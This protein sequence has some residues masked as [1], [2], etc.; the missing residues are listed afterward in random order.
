MVFFN[1][2]EIK[3]LSLKR[4]VKDLVLENEPIKAIKLV[5]EVKHKSLKDAKYYVDVIRWKLGKVQPW[6]TDPRKKVI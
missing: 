3:L 5:R 4:K 2:V 6:E 1:F